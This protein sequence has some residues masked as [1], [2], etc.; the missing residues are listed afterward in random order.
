MQLQPP[1]KVEYDI[2][3]YNKLKLGFELGIF[4]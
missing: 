3:L 1:K 2:R 4:Y